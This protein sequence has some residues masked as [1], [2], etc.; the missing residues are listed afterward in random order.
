[1]QA[2]RWQRIGLQRAPVA[3]VVVFVVTA[4]TSI[5][6]LVRPGVLA[7]LQRTPQGLHGDWWRSLTSL[8]VQ[9]G[10]VVGTISNLAFLL[11]LGALA[12]QV[13]GTRQWLVCY[14]GA[15]L[16]GELAGYA[17][18][19]RGAGNSV[20]ICGL[21]GALGVALLAEAPV[22]RLAPVVLLYWCG[23]LL[24]LL[25]TPALLAGLAAGLA[26]QAALARGLPVGRLVGVAAAATALILVAAR[27]LHGAAMVAGIALGAVV[28]RPSGLSPAATW[29]PC[30]WRR[31]GGSPR[32]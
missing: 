1:M 8:F 19:P 11:V 23:A 18:Q 2:S 24:A 32:R 12:E 25:W 13:L 10:G 22:P 3:T 27:D 15:G 6:G 5:L 7:A 31:R 26:A 9:D 30:G 16:V 28:G 4:I 14:F 17:W 20:A 21:A 29:G